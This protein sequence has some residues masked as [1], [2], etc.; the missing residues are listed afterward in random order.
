MP[1][2]KR[3]G[4]RKPKPTPRWQ[5]IENVVAALE[6][7]CRGVPGLTITQKA[8][9]PVYHDTSRARDVDVLVRYPVGNRVFSLGIEVKA[10]VRPLTVGHLGQI[11]DLWHEVRL[12]R[13][14]VV[15]LSGFSK[16]A[17]IKAR[18]AKLESWTI[19][20][21]ERSEFW[22]REPGMLVTTREVVPEAMCLRYSAAAL[23]EELREPLNA[24]L[25]DAAR[26][27]GLL[28]RDHSGTG[29]LT[30]FVANCGVKA[31]ET[32]TGIF[33][34]QDMFRLTIDMREKRASGTTLLA[35]A[36]VF[37]VP[38]EI[39]AMLRVHVTEELVPER[40]FRIGSTEM[41]ATE[42]TL[43]EQFVQ[44]TV[45]LEPQTD[46]TRKIVHIALGPAQPEDVDVEREP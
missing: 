33:V 6:T 3:P 42:L 12:D 4:Q 44:S 41:L 39:E 25:G 2:T 31:L 15:S 18:E 9:V 17:A 13:F 7:A 29:A 40:R 5:V 19:H 45:I 21:F 27:A 23:P 20:E 11:L 14:A 35:D 1:R 37:P 38:E 16:D 22:H 34:D 43:G 10:H 28:L 36:Q 46:G 24:V 32:H 30:R 26:M 8:Q